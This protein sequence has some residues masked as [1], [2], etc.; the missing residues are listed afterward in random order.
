MSELTSTTVTI[1]KIERIGHEITLLPKRPDRFRNWRPVIVLDGEEIG[2]PRFEVDPITKK[3]IFDL[4]YRRI[5][6]LRI[7]LSSGETLSV[8]SSKLRC[9]ALGSL[10]SIEMF[11]TEVGILGRRYTYKDAEH[12]LVG[13]VLST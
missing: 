13:Q 9:L 8:C 4:P 6:E 7:N 2:M 3:H 11:P 12:F 10:S 1:D 5:W